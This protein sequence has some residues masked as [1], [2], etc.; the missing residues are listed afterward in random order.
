VERNGNG[1]GIWTEREVSLLFHECITS[2][3]LAN[4]VLRVRLRL[5]PACTH[6]IVT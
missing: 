3:E 4:V 1:T 5:K 2:E 6:V